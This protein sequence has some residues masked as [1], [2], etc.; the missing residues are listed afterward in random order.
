VWNK[1]NAISGL[2]GGD[3]GIVSLTSGGGNP[4]IIF[5]GRCYQ[6]LTKA[7]PTLVNG[8]VR[9]LPTSVWECYDLRTGQVYWDLT[10]VTAPSYIEYSSGTESVVGAAAAAAGI[11]PSLVAI[12]GNRL[13]KYNP[14]TGAV[15]LNVS[16]P[17]FSTNTYYM[18]MYVLSVQTIVPSTGTGP[19]PNGVFR[20]INWTTRGTSTNFTTRIMSNITWPWDPTFSGAWTYDFST[21]I[22]FQAMEINWLN[23]FPYVDISYD[24][25]TGDRW[26]TQAQAFDMARGTLLWNLTYPEEHMY[27][28]MDYVADHGKVAILEMGNETN[29]PYNFLVLDQY[30]GKVAY[31]GGLMDYPWGYPAF[32]AYAIQSAYGLFYRQAYNYVY[33]FYWGNGSVAWKYEAPAN[34]YE[35]PYTD[36]NGH[37]VYSWN[38]GGV[39][40]DGKMYVPNT[41]HSPSQ[42]ITRGWSLHCINATTGEGIWKIDGS[43]S[44]GPMADGYLT[45]SNSYDGYTYCFGKGKSATAVTAPDTVVPQGTGV[46]IKGTILDMS[47]AQTGTPCVSASSMET[48]MEYLHMQRPI[49]GLYH[50]ETITG[51]PVTFTAIGSD[52]TVIDIG[53]T[54]TNGYYGTFAY[55]W[56]PPKEDTYTILASF[57]GDGSYGSSSAATAVSVGPAPAVSPTPTPPEAPPDN[58]GLLYGIMAAV[59]IAIIVGIVA[60]LLALRRR[61]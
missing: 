48:Q 7:M 53:S 51:V 50:N 39:I 29:G 45:A 26:G 1:Q 5:Q 56:T 3:N 55:A 21:N 60:I 14:T 32:G 18:N 42:P 31:K 19:G 12:S 40:A 35:T 30:T 10:D 20:L 36:E 13:I 46:L 52:G 11:T 47:P 17:T 33:A 34:P 9:T 49:D 16:I 44:P 25:A 22:A 37:T 58:T 43:M 38:A 41:E 57:A 6:T 2:L 8:T 23:G 4:N 24:S 15:T 61:Q 54:T 59:I 27:I 28:M